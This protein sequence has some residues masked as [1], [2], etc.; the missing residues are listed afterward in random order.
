MINKTTKSL[1][2]PII[3]T[4]YEA[5]LMQ[6]QTCSNVDGPTWMNKMDE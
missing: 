3:L 6:P 5:V 1:L 2:I 4:I